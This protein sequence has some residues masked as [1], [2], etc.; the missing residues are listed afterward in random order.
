MPEQIISRS[1]KLYEILHLSSFGTNVVSIG[2]RLGLS[3]NDLDLCFDYL[4]KNNLIEISD[5]ES[6]KM[7]YITGRGEQVFKKISQHF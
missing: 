7:V 5:S 6:G 2:I 3:K 4:Q 1:Q